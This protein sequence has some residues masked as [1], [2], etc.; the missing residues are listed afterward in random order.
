MKLGNKIAEDQ[1]KVLFIGNENDFVEL[2]FEIH[3]NDD[4]T[5]TF[6]AEEFFNYEGTNLTEFSKLDAA[7]LKR[8]VAEGEFNYSDSDEYWF[9]SA[10][11]LQLVY[12]VKEKCVFVFT[13]GEKQLGN[14]FLALEGTWELV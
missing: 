8:L 11:H 13:F 2:E 1:T 9:K 5:V 10:K 14:W 12:F 4:L 7:G 6:Q 3:V